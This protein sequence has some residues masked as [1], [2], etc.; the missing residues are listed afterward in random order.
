MRSGD[1]LAESQQG[2]EARELIERSRRELGDRLDAD[3]DARLSF[4]EGIG[5]LFELDRDGALE[6]A[7][8]ALRGLDLSSPRGYFL[9]SVAFIGWYLD[10]GV[11]RRHLTPPCG[12]I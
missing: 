2:T 12:T 3:T 8:H 5:C 6:K 11:E 4:I 10:R 1:L 9:D 7:G